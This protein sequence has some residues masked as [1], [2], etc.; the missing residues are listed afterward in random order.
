MATCAPQN[1]L[2]FHFLVPNT[3]V[4]VMLATR[5]AL[6]TWLLI[7]ILTPLNLAT[8]RM[9]VILRL[10]AVLQ[11][12]LSQ[13]LCLPSTLLSFVVLAFLG[14]FSLVVVLKPR[15]LWAIAYNYV[16]TETNVP[17]KV[18]ALRQLVPSLRRTLP[19][20]PTLL[21]VLAFLVLFS[22]TE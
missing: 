21:S 4:L 9:S 8:I 13:L 18:V 15:T 12:V 7:L 6:V 19:S 2:A 11:L 5:Q 3:I 14:L 1:R 16:W 22:Q 20:I 10:V 17:P